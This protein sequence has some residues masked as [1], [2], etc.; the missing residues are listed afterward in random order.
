MESKINIYDNI[1][2]AIDLTIESIVDLA[3]KK[4][5]IKNYK[6]TVINLHNALELIFKF[7]IQN[8][9]EFMLFSMGNN[10]FDKIMSKYKKI[11][12]EGFSSILEYSER[13]KD[14]SFLPHTISFCNAYEIL[15]FLYDENDF[16]IRFLSALQLLENKRNGLT[17]YESTVYRKD[18]VIFKELLFKAIELY[19]N[20]ID[21]VER[22]NLL[23]L[24][25]N[26]AIHYDYPFDPYD[27]T[28][29]KIC[30]EVIE[31][32]IL[33]DEVDKI[34]IGAIVDC[35]SSEL[36]SVNLE[37]RDKITD[38][39]YNSKKDILK[40]VKNEKE[41]VIKREIDSKLTYLI[42]ADML[43]QKDIIVD[44]NGTAYLDSIE[45]TYSA[46]QIINNFFSN[47]KLEMI[48]SLH[49]QSNHTLEWDMD[50]DPYYEEN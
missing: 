5:Y 46:C 17:H 26:K 29:S 45:I 38:I 10:S 41:L 20:E 50:Y 47:D 27:D 34:I 30:E 11:H 28:V 8:R 15:A 19:N 42:A 12:Q 18:L 39:I 9:N 23:T 7:M 33:N 13:Y 21:C 31:T 49:I 4:D 6:A 44:E 24:K 37:N 25:E 35:R 14:E 40:S 48:K 16:D 1:V 36:I 32:E 43:R 3:N 22:K 2:A